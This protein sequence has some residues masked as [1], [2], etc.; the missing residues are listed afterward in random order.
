MKNPS[1]SGLLIEPQRHAF[2]SLKK[3]Y[4]GESARLQFINGLLSDKQGQEELFFIP[5]REIAKCGLHDWANEVA[6]TDASHLWKHFPGVL[7]KSELVMAYTFDQLAKLL[8]TSRVD[9]VV[10][11]VEGAEKRLIDSIDF[12]VH[13]VSFLIFE[14][15]HMGNRD[16]M[17]VSDLLKSMNFELKSFGRDTIAWRR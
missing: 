13:S 14:H 3:N 12:E 1:W 17:A 11:D 7:L 4:F 9:L 2:E 16:F 6:S 10:M 15:K 8:P 5:E